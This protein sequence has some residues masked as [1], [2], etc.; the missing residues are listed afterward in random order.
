MKCFAAGAEERRR[1]RRRGGE[2][3]KGEKKLLQ[4]SACSPP[5]NQ[6]MAI[7]GT[8]VFSKSRLERLLT[9]P[10]PANAI[11]AWRTHGGALDRPR[12]E[13]WGELW[14]IL[15]VASS[16]VG[17]CLPCACLCFCGGAAAVFTR[18]ETVCWASSFVLQTKA[19]VRVKGNVKKV[20]VH[21]G[22][23]VVDGSSLK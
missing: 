8:T 13:G 2:E 9:L 14:W 15:S 10:S 23:N 3:E 22:R 4:L 5:S 7:L 19:F 17:T 1:G 21:L 18:N 12:L 11:P 20:L 16:L 6:T